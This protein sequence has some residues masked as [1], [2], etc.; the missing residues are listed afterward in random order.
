MSIV[1]SLTLS[2]SLS[3]LMSTS[4]MAQVESPQQFDDYRVHFNAL[5]SQHLQSQMAKQYQIERSAKSGL[6]TVVVQKHSDDGTDM[7]VS[8]TISGKAVSLT[9]LETPV[10]MR[11]IREG[12]DI[13]YIGE[14][15]VKGPD[16]YRFT[17]SIRPEGAARGYTLK[18]EQN[19]AGN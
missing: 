10:R 12:D 11:E 17:L 19:Y 6:V 15:A 5:S 14:F 9:G 18:F 2:L 8:A 3:I 16:T 4:A 7:P 1:R 13:S